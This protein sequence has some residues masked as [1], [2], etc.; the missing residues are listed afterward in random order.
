MMENT[1]SVTLASSK[2]NTF[3]KTLLLKDQLKNLF[4]NNTL[5]T[6]WINVLKNI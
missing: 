2:N 1:L 3:T 6:T 5:L 4:A